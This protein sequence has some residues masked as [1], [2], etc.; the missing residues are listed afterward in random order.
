MRT[1]NDGRYL[2]TDLK[3]L[4]EGKGFTWHFEIGAIKTR[5]I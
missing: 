3:L 1:F 5:S 4:D 2:E